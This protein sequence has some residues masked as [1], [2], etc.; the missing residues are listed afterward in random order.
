M[1]IAERCA[2]AVRLHRAGRLREAELGYREILA[3]DPRHADSLHLL[4]ALAVESRQYAEAVELIG[5]ALDLVPYCVAA[6]LNLGNAL[7]GLGRTTEA[8]AAY[9]RALELRPECAEGHYNRANAL[10]SSGAAAEAL[11]AFYRALELKPDYLKAYNNLGNTLC[12]LGRLDEAVAIWRRGLDVKPDAELYNN[13]ANALNDL[14]RAEEA[15]ALYDRAAGLQKPGFDSPL[16]NKALLLIE[17]GR[18]AQALRATDEALAVNPAS[19]AAW[20]IRSE[21]KKFAAAD[22]E[23]EAMEGLL[24]GPEADSISIADRIRLQFALGKAWLDAGD[25]ARA[26]AH[27]DDANRLKRSTLTYDA[28]ATGRWM[29]AI[30]AAFTPDLMQRLAGAGHPSAAPVF[31]VGMP[32]SGTTLVEQILASHPAI[33]GAGELQVLRDLVARH[34]GVVGYPGCVAHL[35]P[36]ELTQLGREY[37][38]QACALAPAGGRV[39]D[40][41]PF[42]FLYA[43]LIHLMLPNAR[44][45]HCRRD[46]ADT[47]LSCYTRTF[48][49]PVE[50]AYDLSELGLYYR[51]Y[52]ALMGHWRAL[53]PA[54]CLIEIHYEDLV[55]HLEPQARRLVAFCGLEW[56]GACLAFHQT[57]RQ[58]RTASATQVRQ[59][60]YHSSIGRWKAYERYLG[61]LLAALDPYGTSR[62]LRVE[63]TH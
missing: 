5:Q 32:R 20:Y 42:N 17:M 4:G 62:S 22:A 29:E 57:R 47:C 45:I 25:A 23:I 52:E 13:L 2:Q 12:E 61:P 7:L 11:A 53:L 54:E 18:T 15:L 10:L 38:Q 55:H 8:I 34:S 46:A 37:V 19:A 36:E 44:I 30:A 49:G 60:V 14:G 59:P 28:E 27:L 40:K 43:A 21:L 31:V 41:M 6:H 35:L 3:I 63:A 33:H 39:V 16:A 58:V 9:N 48:R 51:R 26:F 50:F 1:N 56:N 24:V